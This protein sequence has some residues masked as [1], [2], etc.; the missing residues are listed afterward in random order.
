MQLQVIKRVQYVRHCQLLLCLLFMS[1]LQFYKTSELKI[2]IRLPGDLGMSEKVKKQVVS[3]QCL[4]H[5]ISL[6]M[7]TPNFLVVWPVSTAEPC[8]TAC[9]QDIE[10]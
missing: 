9:T 5:F 4:T 10:A 8:I 3:A 6:E 1:L 2:C 7:C